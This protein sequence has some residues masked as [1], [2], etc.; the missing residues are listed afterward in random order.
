MGRALNSD[1]DYYRYCT[2][3]AGEVE[4]WLAGA[5]G[6]DMVR[7][8]GRFHIHLPAVDD[9]PAVRIYIAYGEVSVTIAES[10][11]TDVAYDV[12]I[13]LPALVA[14]LTRLIE[15]DLCEESVR[16]FGANRRRWRLVSPRDSD[17]AAPR[18]RRLRRWQG[19]RLT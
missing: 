2:S 5:L 8:E 3:L 17:R 9:S 16:P 6:R 1:D 11:E 18:K 7:R 13:G 19:R 10:F 15:A 12:D 4:S 14:G